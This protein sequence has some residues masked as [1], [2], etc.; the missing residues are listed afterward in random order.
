VGRAILRHIHLG[1]RNIHIRLL[2][3]SEQ[4]LQKLGESAEG[5]EPVYGDIFSGD[6]LEKEMKSCDMVIHLVGII[7]EKDGAT[8][9]KVHIEGT[10]CVVDSARK[11]GIRHFVHMSAENARADAPSRYHTTKYQAEEYLKKSG[12]TYTIMR[13]SMMFGPEDQ[14]FNE[15]AKI[16]CSTPV[17]PVIGDGSYIWQPVSVDNVA[18]LFVAVL[19]E[20]RAMGK[21]YE[22]RGPEKF[23][24]EE[25]L[26]ILMEVTGKTRPRIHIPVAIMKPLA[27]LMDIVSSIAPITL[28]QMKMLLDE[29]QPPSENFSADFPIKLTHL[30]EGLRKFLAPCR[31]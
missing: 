25:I 10:K 3:R 24:F 7:K 14:N 19:M 21:T 28:E 5:V 8:F 27:S 23:T 4:S 20:P 11:S 13:P 26:N 29:K 12:L 15:L 30:E 17:M 16:I 31:P 9:E 2:A 1:L 6:I 18:E 22:I